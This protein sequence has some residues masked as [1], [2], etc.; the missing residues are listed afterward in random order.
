[1]KGCGVYCVCVCVVNDGGVLW[2][3]SVWCGVGRGAP[4]RHIAK[5]EG[6]G[7][8]VEGAVLEGQALRVP[9]HPRQRVAHPGVDVWV[10]LAAVQFK[11]LYKKKKKKTLNLHSASAGTR[12]SDGLVE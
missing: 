9:L 2:C 5:A 12:T 6:D 4:V 1:M 10:V 8:E 11:G 3:V 7:V